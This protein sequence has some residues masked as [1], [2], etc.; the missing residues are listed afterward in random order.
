MTLGDTVAVPVGDGVA[1]TDSDVVADAEAVA[2]TDVVAVTEPDTV[3][4]PVAVAL[5]VTLG[6]TLDVKLIKTLAATEADLDELK[7]TL[8]DVLTV[9]V[10]AAVPLLLR[11]DA[12]DGDALVAE[13]L[14]MDALNDA[15]RE[16]LLVL[17]Q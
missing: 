3:R 15:E 12:L 13:E 16:A 4:L 17:L 5:A 8:V 9:T 10:E 1:D 11:D 14:D 7:V 6:D 2:D